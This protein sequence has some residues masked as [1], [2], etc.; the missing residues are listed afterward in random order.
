MSPE[1]GST[2]NHYRLAEKIGAGGMGEVWRAQDTTLK[3]DVAI[4]I[5]PGEFGGDPERQARFER[6]AR[7]LAS[8]QH[9]NV[10]AIYGFERSGDTAFLVM[11]LVEGEDLV[12]RLRR[13]PLSN[14]EALGIAG[15]IIDGLE[16][17]HERGIVHRDL[18]P[19]NLRLADDG[20]GHL[21]V[22]II[23]F[24][25]AR[26]TGVGSLS[27]DSEESPTRTVGATTAGTLL[28]TAAYMSPEQAKAKSVDAR[29]DIWAFGVVL[30]EMLT[31]ESVF[32]RESIA[33]TLSAVLT[34]EPDLS[35]L[36]S[37][38]DSTLNPLIERCLKR[39]LRDRLRHVGD[40]RIFL[41]GSI[42]GARDSGAAAKTKNAGRVGWLLITLAL[43]ALTALISTIWHPGAALPERRVLDLV[44]EGIDRNWTFAPELSPEGTRIAY[45]SRQGLWV[46]R[47]DGLTARLLAEIEDPDEF[48]WSPDGREIAYV[49]ANHLWRVDIDSPTP[50]RICTLPGNGGAV[51]GDWREDG[52][53]VFAA[54]RGGL[55]TVSASGGTPELVMPHEPGKIVDFHTPRWLPD[56]SAIFVIHYQRGPGRTG[57]RNG[58][59][60]SGGESPS[61]IGVL[62]DGELEHVRFP[63]DT[64]VAWLRYDPVTGRLLYSAEGGNTGIFAAEFNVATRAVTGEPQLIFPSGFSFSLATN[65]SL[66]YT[67]GIKSL[68]GSELVRVDM[69]GRLESVV[70]RSDHRLEGPVLSPDGKKVVL[71]DWKNEVNS[72]LAIVEIAT[73]SLSPLTFTEKR[74]H[75]P[76]WS[77]S[78]DRVV[79]AE[80][81]DVSADLVT[82]RVDGTGGRRLITENVGIG[83]EDALAFFGRDGKQMLYTI[84]REGVFNL[85]LGDLGPDGTVVDS[86]HYFGKE[87]GPTV[88]DVQLSP[89]GTMLAYT[90]IDSGR[91]EVFLTT[92]PDGTGRWAVSRDGGRTP[93]WS[94]G[95]DKLYFVCGSGP[96]KRNFC[97]STVSTDGGVRVGAAQILFHP[98]EM[99]LDLI[100]QGEYA[101]SRDGKNLFVIRSIKDRDNPERMILVQHWATVLDDKP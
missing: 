99:G 57:A 70:A 14:D 48:F 37:G 9:P 34:H 11:E 65:E 64:D 79:Y 91:P 50:V 87:R 76:S 5:L 8:L 54:W 31:G 73:G 3:R 60:V 74:E 51:G 25:L 4:K 42:G 35:Q 49:D 16:A 55:Y 7:A 77:P 92:F 96:N 39:K 43:V 75:N 80:S 68:G 89:D 23:D 97:Y 56:G 40:A 26:D 20:E 81:I 90:A 38:T 47:L 93:H 36:P 44:A 10:A 1:P 82:L 32:A 45:F 6:E 22:K 69:A 12:E 67:E 15:Q 41:E 21:R 53:I 30:Y 78:G 71:V 17:A 2:L 63:P 27:Q 83:S 88:I 98:G 33:E 19:A 61:P 66:L 18:K 95:S 100:A 24:G 101:V 86:R 29:A 28:G 13:R 84:D 94:A 59:D 58:P 62:A 46:R 72:D 52:L 85:M